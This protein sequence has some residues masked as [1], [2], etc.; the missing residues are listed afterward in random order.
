MLFECIGRYLYQSQTR[1]EH[2]GR[3][4]NLFPCIKARA[5][6]ATITFLIQITGSSISS[7]I[8]DNIDFVFFCQFQGPDRVLASNWKFMKKFYLVKI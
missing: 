5:V 1:P 4:P 6:A 2:G 8:V 7:I 3:H